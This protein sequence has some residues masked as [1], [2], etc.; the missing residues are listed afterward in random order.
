MEP[1]TSSSHSPCCS[2][3]CLQALHG[4]QLLSSPGAC[5][6]RGVYKPCHFVTPMCAFCVNSSTALHSAT[7]WG[8]SVS[9]AASK[10][11]P[12][13]HAHTKATRGNTRL[14]NPAKHHHHHSTA[15][16]Y[17]CPHFPQPQANLVSLQQSQYV[18]T[19]SQEEA[20][21]NPLHACAS[22]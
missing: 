11:A 12:L 14:S 21:G 20:E 9:S 7:A 6:F 17:P 18:Q 3:S 19:D 16:A 4:Q 8:S 10:L 15:V 13:G 2:C 1:T 5:R 22:T